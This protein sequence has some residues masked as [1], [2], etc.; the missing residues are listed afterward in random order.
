M[1]LNPKEVQK[2]IERFEKDIIYDCHSLRTRL[3]RSEAREKL[4]EMGRDALRPIIDHLKINSPKDELAEAW[5]TLFAWIEKDID[6]KRS[7]PK[8]V[9]SGEIINW[10][11]W[12]EKFTT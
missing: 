9:D 4:N 11:E 6:P 7:G 10:I 12:A 1:S 8:Y 3:S 5:N 2:L